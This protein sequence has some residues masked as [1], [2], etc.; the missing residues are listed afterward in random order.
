VAGGLIPRPGR[1][2]AVVSAA[3]Q[4]RPL[5]PRAG[6]RRGRAS[7]ATDRYTDFSI[8]GKIPGLDLGSNACFDDSRI[9]R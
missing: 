6:R 5:L 2:E 4:F 9:R 7:V 1:P 3:R 8:N